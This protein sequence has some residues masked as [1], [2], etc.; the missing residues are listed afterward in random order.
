[1]IYRGEAPAFI[2]CPGMVGVHDKERGKKVEGRHETINNRLKIFSCVAE[3]YKGKQ[4]T[5]EDKIRDHGAMFTAVVVVTE[6][7][8]QLGFRNMMELQE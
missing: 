3:R 7:S 2:K 4:N 5:P 8:M 1:M 6:I